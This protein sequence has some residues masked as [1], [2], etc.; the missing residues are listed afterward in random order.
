M[1]SQ[2]IDCAQAD[3]WTEKQVKHDLRQFHSVR[4]ADIISPIECKQSKV[5]HHLNY[6]GQC[7]THI[8]LYTTV[9]STV[10]LLL[11]DCL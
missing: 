4:L 10:E 5:Q 8:K 2:S 7:G 6:V 1:M 3:G 9:P 11:E